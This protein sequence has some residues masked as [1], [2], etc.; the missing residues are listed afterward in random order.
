MPAK[1]STTKGKTAKPAGGP[2]PVEAQ[3]TGTFQLPPPDILKKTI[4][5]FYSLAFIASQTLPEFVAW[6]AAKREELAAAA[7]MDPIEYFRGVAPEVCRRIVAFHQATRNPDPK[8]VAGLTGKALTLDQSPECLRDYQQEMSRIA[9]L[10]GRAL[11]ENR[12]HR[13]QGCA[14]CLAACQ[15]GF[16][17]L[18]SDP[19]F[20]VLEATLREEAARPVEQQTPLRP[21]YA[22]AVAHL[23]KVTGSTR[24]SL[25][26][27]NLT[28]LAYCLLLLGMARSRRAAPERQLAIF[29]G[30][31]QIFAHNL[32]R[33]GT[34]AKEVPTPA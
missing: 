29:Q 11:P 4:A 30:A 27:E 28:N 15:F 34:P 25:T 23:G 13:R 8:L 26:L 14:M 24:G 16:F 33:G 22:F 12:L 20:S 10:P 9:A 17:S 31:S 5:Y 32:R 2:E 1:K 18:V 19:A 21:V 6:T 7:H 3:S